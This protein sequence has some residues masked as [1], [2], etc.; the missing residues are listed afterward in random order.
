MKI[1]YVIPGTGGAFYCENCVRDLSLVKG[2]VEQG[3][4]ICVGSM[5]LPAMPDEPHPVKESP[6]FYGAVRLYLEHRW[7]A[8]QRLPF[9][10]RKVLDSGPLIALAA[11]RAGSTRASGLE[12]LTIDMLRGEAGSQA[13]ELDRLV[14]W[15]GEHVQPDVVHL[16]NALLLGLAP[17]MRSALGARV[18]CSLQD[19][20]SW[21]ATMP[22]SY[23][24][25][26]WALMAQHT[27]GVTCVAVSRYY[28]D[29]VQ[30][31]L[32]LEDGQLH[33]IPLGVDTETF[34]P[35]ASPP[36]VPTIGF[37][38]RLNEGLG[39]GVLVDAFSE[40]K[41]DPAFRSLRLRLAGG[42]TPEDSRFIRTIRRSLRR[43]GVLQDVDFVEEFDPERRAE[44]LRTLTLLSVPILEGEAFGLFQLEAMASGVPVVQPAVGGFPEVAELTGGSLV[45]EPD[46]T[47]SLVT[48][49]RR[50]LSDETERNALAREGLT[51]AHNR[52]TIRQMATR[53]SE[54]YQNAE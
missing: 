16:S 51:S 12:E 23:P 45:Y 1:A 32:G 18:V 27:Q 39:L 46:D 41:R 26:V 13:A 20:A 5:Y 11:R 15:L 2:L 42:S 22:G 34:T 10:V 29:H 14:R 49:L 40:L 50:V 6:V 52:F 54:V 28:A 7:P 24:A 38:S 53:M 43:E 3:H 21:V 33:V 35:A 36:G 31:L 17:R 9:G 44:F 30:P 37:L 47:A 19:E 48:A 25:R 8:L 4:E